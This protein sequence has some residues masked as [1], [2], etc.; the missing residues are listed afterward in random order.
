MVEGGSGSIVPLIPI[1]RSGWSFYPLAP[2]AFSMNK[3]AP[4][5]Y[6]Y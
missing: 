2:V 4:L 5:R 1:L 6:E 3:E